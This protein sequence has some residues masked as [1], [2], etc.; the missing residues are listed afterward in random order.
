MIFSCMD[1][2][3]L[4]TLLFEVTVLFYLEKKA[5]NTIY[6][7]LNFL[8]L[9]YVA[10][11]LITIAVAGS[12]FGFVE[13]YYPSILLWI[14]GLLLFAI[15]SYLISFVVQKGGR[16]LNCNLDKSQMPRILIVASAFL[17]LIMIYHL[18]STLGSS[19]EA[20]GSDEFGEDFSGHGIWGQIRML[21][22]PLLVMSIYYVD[23][24]RWWVWIFIAVFVL[25]SLLNQV[26]GWTIIPSLAGICLRL[27]T[28]KTKLS[29]KLVFW[30]VAGAFLVFFASYAMSILLVQDRGV[31]NDFMQFIFGHFFHYLTS[32]TIGLSEDA[33]RGYPDAG[34]S[35]QTV[36]AQLVN[37]CK[38]LTGD[39]DMVY[40]VNPLYYFSGVDVAL[41]NVRTFFGTVY[42]NSTPFV[43]CIYVLFISTMMYMMRLAM[44]K[45]NNIY[46][47]T[48]YF[49]YGSLLFMGWF[50]LYFANLTILE[51]PILVMIY[52]LAEKMLQGKKVV[53]N[54]S[55]NSFEL[56]RGR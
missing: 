56:E 5:W 19:T 43:F 41:T 44:L 45:F 46:M 8:M 20:L 34:G 15:P 51:F 42:I 17:C 13:F 29:Y 3:L 27:Y 38:L 16:P 7:P 30:V 9:P 24:R 50:D 40:P 31:S 39:S 52:M 1:F 36:I 10:V 23:A 37:I 55:N 25:V 4:T 47:F 35:F 11:L 2:L 32:G 48:I 54:D 33:M 21:T 28:G 49:F 22:M 6:T 18:K 14:V 53:Q 26:K 12:R